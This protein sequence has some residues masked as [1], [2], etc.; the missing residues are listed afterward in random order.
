MMWIEIGLNLLLTLRVAMF[1]LTLPCLL[2]FKGDNL[3]LVDRDGE[4][5]CILL[6]V[7]NLDEPS[8]LLDNARHNRG[9][10]NYIFM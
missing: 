8:Q 7:G 4:L 3:L 6:D 2:A 10:C 1:R 9:F 5:E